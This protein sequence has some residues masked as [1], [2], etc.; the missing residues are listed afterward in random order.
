MLKIKKKFNDIKNIK[1]N[2]LKKF[3]IKIDYL[4]LRNEQ[5]L[6]IYNKKNKFRLFIAYHLNNIRLI[7]NF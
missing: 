6:K 7:D 2:L 3:R 5:N 1:Q 4:E